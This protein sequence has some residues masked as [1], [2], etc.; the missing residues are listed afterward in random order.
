MQDISWAIYK[1]G[2]CSAG[3]LRV[4][5]CRLDLGPATAHERECYRGERAVQEPECADQLLCSEHPDCWETE[6]QRA[7]DLGTRVGITC[8]CVDLFGRICLLGLSTLGN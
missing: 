2:Q 7:A 1:S 3:S 8:C 6:P 4:Q 5:A